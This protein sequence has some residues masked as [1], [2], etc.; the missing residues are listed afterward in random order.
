MFKQTT[1]ASAI[2]AAIASSSA[3]AATIE[4]VTVTA[5]K[6]AE[7]TQDIPVAVS[8][9]G[10]EKLEQ[11]GV[12]NFQDYMVQMPGITAGGSGPGQNTIYIRG[13]A[14][15]TPNLTTAGVAGLAPNVALYLDEQPL[16]QP[17]RNL[18]VYA[19]DLNRV[20]VLAG[21]QGTLFGASSQAGTVRLITNKPDP[22]DAGGNIKVGTSFTSGGEPSQNLEAV[23]NLPLTNTLTL[24]GVV[25]VDHQ[26][27]YIDNV[28]GTRSAAE[29]A[30]FRPEGTLRDNGVAVSAQR[31]GIQHDAD[32]S[33]VTFLEADN[34]DLVQKDFND[35]TYTGGRLSGLWDINEDWSL[36]VGYAQQTID[37]DG[38]FFVDPDL[39]DMEIQR[40][41]EDSLEDSYQNVNWTLEGRLA[42][43]EM[44]YTGAFTKRDS[45]QLVDYSDYLFVGQYLPYYICDGSV[46]YGGDAPSGTC[47]APNLYVNSTS[48]AE[49]GTHELRFSTPDDK[50]IH[51]TFGAFYSD[52]ELRERND[53]TYP[54][55]TQVAG[56]AEGQTGFGPNKSFTT[57]YTSDAGP[58]PEG[59]IFRN[60]VKR[61]DQQMGAFGEVTF[62][63]SDAF[64]AIVGARYYD[65]EVDFEGSAN[66]SFCNLGGETVDDDAN[67][68]G[69]DISDIYNGDGEYTFRGA[70]DTDRHITYTRD[71]SL[72]EIMA[73]DPELSAEQAN[74]I[75]NATRAPDVAAT[76]GTI[77]KFTLQ[78]M[79]TDDHLLYATASEG[80]RPGLLNRPGGA[81]AGD[82]TVPFALDTDDTTNYE[83]G[84][85]TDLLDGQLRFNGSLFFVE[86]EKLQTTI[87]DPSI[88]NLFFSD[89]AANAEVKGVEGDFTWAPDMVSGLLVS[90]SFS[91][92]DTEIT[93]VLTPTDDVQVGDELA[94]APKFQANLQA[95][96]EWEGFSGSTYHVMPHVTYSD[97]SY[98]DI[99]SI[100]RMELDSWAM[101]GLTA[102]ITTDKWSAEF[103]GKN[104][105]D[106]RAELSGNFVFDRSRVSVS[107]PRTFG[108]RGSY[109]F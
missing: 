33:D 90:G 95:R 67:A 104:L 17:G 22:T 57:G 59:V 83:L 54:G 89:N 65:I 107:R 37:S 80:F 92:L 63:L 106:E 19:A 25:Y 1:L 56:W 96:Y 12:S 86:I 64:S 42:E 85:K 82:Y 2:V 10:E 27:G 14:S 40:F 53:F 60:D 94:F 7:S 48:E 93:E 78:W 16:S 61:T 36:L 58:Y 46:S 51:A 15:T 11:M 5:T 29:S 21:P 70:C 35:T 97:S 100:N 20:E 87:F 73:T 76:D 52:M 74:Q 28:A 105:T 98:T 41:S 81:S 49:V 44:V 8:A 26:G 66:S 101:L 75:F 4:E 108:I 103:F 50:R 23:A 102:G 77:F 109:H 3:H 9:M 30:R 47:Q 32:L 6:R 62:E 99:I 69:T 24:R 18:D 91:V 45:D 38:V 79:P 72:E 84:W 34:A 55:S 13:V 71:M 39:D 88:T 43:L 31:R 68:F